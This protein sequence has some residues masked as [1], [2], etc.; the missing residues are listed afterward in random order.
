MTQEN[1]R[2][3]LKQVFARRVTTQARVVLDTYQ[4][5][6][7]SDWQETPRLL[8]LR[9]GLNKLDRY[10]TRFDLRRHKDAA[11]AILEVL[12]GLAGPRPEPD[13]AEALEKAMQKLNHCTQRKSDTTAD[14]CD[15]APEAPRT[16]LR[17]PVYLALNDGLYADRIINQLEFFGFRS[18][19]FDNADDLIEASR[20]NKPETIVADVDFNGGNCRGI[21]VISRIQANH[22]TP[23]PIIFVSDRLDDM[24][25]RLM[26]S[27]NGGEEFFYRA[28]DPGQLIEKIEL[29]THASPLEPYRV[30]VVDDSRSQ[31]R[32]IENIL[33]KAG[34]V[35]RAINDPMQVLL[36]LEDFQPE[37]IIL[38]MYMPGCTGMEL[39]RVIRQQD[40]FHSVPIIY[41][42]AEDDLNKQLH[43]M[44][45]GGDD[46]LTKPINPRHLTATLLNRGRR[47]RS[48]LA[49]MIRDSLTGLYNHTH[50]LHLLE[51]EI[52]KATKKGQGLCFAMLDIDHFKKIN[53]SYGHPIGDRVLKSLSLFLKQRLRKTD[54]IGRY[55]G[56]EFAVILTNTFETDAR[57]ILDEIRERFNELPQPVGQDSFHVSFSCGIAGLNDESAQ[58]LCEKADQ[59]LYAAKREGRNSV[60]VYTPE[61]KS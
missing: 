28:I 27:R 29:Y 3:K 34:M 5:W 39:A 26:A 49:L 56:E 19:S 38:D 17:T 6:R 31:S 30:L 21:E 4:K 47:A 20:Q 41:L 22:E 25:T 40:K 51:I 15:K 12:N 13:Q 61:L 16:F 11:L 32:H 45:L 7:A 59:A 52:A 24:Q 58:L 50:T 33:S 44:S 35:V 43:A 53:D 57:T 8:D 36:A 10:A 23:I 54:Y 1:Q 42:S 18:I 9:D 37:I 2:E 55:G 60:R 48:L 46:F 14:G